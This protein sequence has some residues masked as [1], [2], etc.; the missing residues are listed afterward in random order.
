MSFNYSRI[1]IRV[2]KSDEIEFLTKPSTI[3]F[4]KNE[5]ADITFAALSPLGDEFITTNV[6]QD[7][8]FLYYQPDQVTPS[9]Y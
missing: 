2:Y 6:D 9:H 3:F 5:P 7:C 8:K 1:K 4:R